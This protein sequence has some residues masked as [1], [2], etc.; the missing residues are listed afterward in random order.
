MQ[1]GIQQVWCELTLTTDLNCKIAAIGVWGA[2]FA[3]TAALVQRL[4]GNAVNGPPLDGPKPEVI[5][6][7]ERRRAPLTVRLAVEASWQATQNAAISPQALKCV[8]VSGLGDTELTDYMCQVLASANKQ[9][10][11]TKFHNSVHNAPAG[12]WTISTGAMS[13]ANS[14]AGFQTSVSIALL[15][16]MV[17]CQQE[18]TPMLVT[19]YDA[20]VA[21]TLQSILKNDQAFSASLVIYPADSHRDG[22]L[23]K[24]RVVC[25]AAQWPTIQ[26]TDVTLQDLYQVNPSAKIL[27]LLEKLLL[28]DT[29]PGPLRLPLSLGT[30]IDLW[31]A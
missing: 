25:E 8:F 30:S 19:F 16:A 28:D 9:L 23:L 12:Y 18:Q 17:Q 15:E 1:P 10:S 7:N 5:P 13:A 3:D 24:A 21:L 4:E 26:A 29:S 11:P 6:A 22:T 14:V 20:P 27:C 31:L 2:H